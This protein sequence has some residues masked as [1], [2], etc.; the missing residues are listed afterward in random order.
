[1]SSGDNAE[2]YYISNSDNINKPFLCG[3]QTGYEGKNTNFGIN[4]N[5]D[6]RD[7]YLDKTEALEKFYEQQEQVLGRPLTAVEK[8]D[9]NYENSYSTICRKL[10]NYN[11]DITIEKNENKLLYSTGD[12]YIP[13]N[14][15]YLHSDY[16]QTE[17]INK[18]KWKNQKCIISKHYDKNAV[19]KDKLLNEVAKQGRS[20]RKN[21]KQCCSLLKKIGYEF[22]DNDKID[23]LI[24]EDLN[25]EYCSGINKTDCNNKNHICDWFSGG[26][27]WLINEIYEK[28]KENNNRNLYDET[29]EILSKINKFQSI[30]FEEFQ[31][32][33]KQNFKNL[34]P[35]LKNVSELLLYKARSRVRYPNN[36]DYYI[37]IKD[38]EDFDDIRKYTDRKQRDGRFSIKDYPGGKCLRKDTDRKSTPQRSIDNYRRQ[39]QNEQLLTDTDRQNYIEQIE[40]LQDNYLLQKKFIDSKIQEY[41]DEIARLDSEIINFE[42]LTAEYEKTRVDDNF[43]ISELKK[44]KKDYQS[45]SL[46]LHSKIAVLEEDKQNLKIKID[47]LEL[48]KEG[49]KTNITNLEENNKKLENH[50]IDLEKKIVS[51]NLRLSLINEENVIENIELK[52]IQDNLKSCKEDLQNYKYKYLYEKSKNQINK[53]KIKK[54][55]KNISDLEENINKIEEEL[56]LIDTETQFNLSNFCE[57]ETNE[58]NKNYNKEL[59]KY[60]IISH[61][62]DL[63]LDE[64][65]NVSEDD[66]TKTL[67]K[68]LYNKLINF[69]D[70]QIK[71]VKETQPLL[72]KIYQNIVLNKDII[73]TFGNDKDTIS[74]VLNSI[75]KLNPMEIFKPIYKIL[76]SDLTID[77][78]SIIETNISFY[79]ERDEFNEVNIQLKLKQLRIEFNN[80]GLVEVYNKL[81][82]LIDN[83]FIKKFKFYKYNLRNMN[84]EN[85][86]SCL[87]Y[88][89]PYIL[90]FV[91]DYLDNLDIFI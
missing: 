38:L 3:V 4:I 30:T 80:I 37:Q 27:T 88:I 36:D 86:L 26:R 14:L 83:K 42:E 82:E 9:L 13:E 18:S 66:N 2:Y 91:Y 12:E 79:L 72:Y 69:T 6:P 64:E 75:D 10:Y 84:E 68:F 47:K 56:G 58:T 20:I 8:K 1:M 29:M 11:S 85:N 81:N 78:D 21:K 43:K 52:K 57:S 46:D 35:N 7:H 15:N 65:N 73:S 5:G 55:E 76:K 67:L 53:K 62:L 19:S 89:Y 24:N 54:Y 48:E 41:R 28:L 45:P 39:I 60:I 44:K 49:L 71:N 34:F 59:I 50:I 17:D 40:K 25:N 87:H 61:F 16:P 23:E 31:N 63:Q 74:N 90:A 33:T 32:Y 77:N 51:I 70:K 22:S